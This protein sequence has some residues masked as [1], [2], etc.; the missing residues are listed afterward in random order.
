MSTRRHAPNVA[1]PGKKICPICGKPSY[2]TGGVH[3]QCA[4]L[5]ADVTRQKERKTKQA[6]LPEKPQRRSWQKKCPTCGKE[7]HVSKRICPCGHRF[8]G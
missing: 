6:Q 1:E 7:L 5:Q 8:D 2:S 4:V 3:P